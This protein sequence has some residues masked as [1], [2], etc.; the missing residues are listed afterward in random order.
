[1]VQRGSYG[2]IQISNEIAIIPKKVP[3]TGLDSL[4]KIINRKVALIEER[5]LRS[6]L[7]VA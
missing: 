4:W 6:T 1:M 7:L 2:S 5:T 3:N